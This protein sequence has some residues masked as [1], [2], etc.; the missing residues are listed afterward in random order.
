MGPVAGDRAGPLQGPKTQRRK[1][2]SE[3]L[4]TAREMTGHGI[5]DYARREN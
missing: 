2:F 5:G 3:W 4:D 1:A